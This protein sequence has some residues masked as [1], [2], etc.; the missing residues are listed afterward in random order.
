MLTRDTNWLWVKTIYTVS[1]TRRWATQ[2]DYAPVFIYFKRYEH[3][4]LSPMIAK[5]GRLSTVTLTLFGH[6]AKFGCS[7][8]YDV[9]SQKIGTLMTRPLGNGGMADPKTCPSPTRV[10]LPNL[11]SDGQ[12]VWADI[13]HE[14]WAPRVPPFRATS[15]PQLTQIDQI[16]TTSY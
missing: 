5:R 8:S 9:G 16:P 7:M 10:T 2:T 13:N 3:R 14:H 6:F 4:L 12:T 11:I 15:P 1:H